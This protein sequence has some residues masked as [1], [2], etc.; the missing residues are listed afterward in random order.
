[1]VTTPATIAREMRPTSTGCCL[2][3]SRRA[4]PLSLNWSSLNSKVFVSGIVDGS[5]E[6]YHHR[7]SPREGGYYYGGV[8]QGRVRFRHPIDAWVTKLRLGS[9]GTRR[10]NLSGEKPKQAY[11]WDTKRQHSH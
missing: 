6:V 10:R 1:M 7:K 9:L 8:G 3:Y 11:G 4:L 5:G 2:A